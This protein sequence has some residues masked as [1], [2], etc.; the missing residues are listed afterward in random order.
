M[1][2]IFVLL[3]QINIFCTTCV[4][5]VQFTVNLCY[6]TLASTSMMQIVTAEALMK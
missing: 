3:F 5:D 1:L 2:F 6:N 4:V